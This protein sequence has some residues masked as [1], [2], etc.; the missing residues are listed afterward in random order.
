MSRQQKRGLLWHILFLMFDSCCWFCK[1]YLVLIQ[2]YALL[3]KITFMFWF[4]KQALPTLIL[5]WPFHSF[6]NSLVTRNALG[7]YH[8]GHWPKL[9]TLKVIRYLEDFQ[10][11]TSQLLQVYST[12]SLQLASKKIHTLTMFCSIK[13]KGIVSDSNNIFLWHES[14]YINQKMLYQKFPLIPILRLQ[15]MHNYVHWHSSIDYC[16]KGALDKFNIISQLFPKKV[17]IFIPLEVLAWVMT[18]CRVL[19]SRL[20]LLLKIYEYF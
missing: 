4:C 18:A 3:P 6:S 19:R 9:W 17:G 15:V 14:E 12:P 11:L 10:W 1:Q 5:Q 7:C 8:H 13:F 20:T 2:I 16:V